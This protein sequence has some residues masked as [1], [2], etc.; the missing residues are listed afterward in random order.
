MSDILFRSCCANE[1]EYIAHFRHGLPILFCKSHF[2]DKSLLFDV[3]KTYNLKTK[4]EVQ[5]V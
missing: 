3:E 4:Q 5:H 1:K 2:N